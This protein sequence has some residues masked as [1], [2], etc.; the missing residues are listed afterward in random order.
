MF[1]TKFRVECAE[2]EERTGELRDACNILV[3]NPERKKSLERPR[4]R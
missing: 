1:L 3:G 2:L 4:F